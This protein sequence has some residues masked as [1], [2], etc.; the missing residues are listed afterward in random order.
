[1]KRLNDLLSGKE[2]IKVAEA[3]VSTIRVKDYI[4]A[5]SNNVDIDFAAVTT[6]VMITNVDSGNGIVFDDG[7][8]DIYGNQ[9]G[10]ALIGGAFKPQ[11]Y[12]TAERVESGEGSII[13]DRTLKKCILYNGTAWVNL[14]GT[15][16]A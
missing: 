7:S 5:S 14:D 13:Y 2:K 12:T 10:V 9:G 8:M 1:M 3:E 11:Q 15:A 6:S 16:L 4:K